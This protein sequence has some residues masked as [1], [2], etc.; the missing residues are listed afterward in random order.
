M[1]PILKKEPWPGTDGGNFNSVGNGTSLTEGWLHIDSRTAFATGR[2]YD[3]GS[4]CDLLKLDSREC[5]KV[6]AAI[7]RVKGSYKEAFP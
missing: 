5:A 7:L 3:V 1:T 2:D 6:R 4:C